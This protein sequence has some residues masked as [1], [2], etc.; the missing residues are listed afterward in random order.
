[1]YTNVLKAVY[2]YLLQLVNVVDKQ[3]VFFTLLL[4]AYCR[5]SQE[6]GPSSTS[7]QRE[8][9]QLENEV[10]AIPETSEVVFKV[11]EIGVTSLSDSKAVLVLTPP[12]LEIV[13]LICLMRELGALG[14][15]WI[16]NIQNML[17]LDPTMSGHPTSTLNSEQYHFN[18]AGVK[19][20]QATDG[21]GTPLTK[22]RQMGLPAWEFYYGVTNQLIRQNI[23][24]SI[25][26]AD[27]LYQ[28][29]LSFGAA[30]SNS[31]FVERYGSLTKVHLEPLVKKNVEDHG[32]DD[33]ENEVRLR[34]IHTVSS[35]S[36]FADGIVDAETLEKRTLDESNPN[37]IFRKVGYEDF[38]GKFGKN[39]TCLEHETKF[40]KNEVRCFFVHPTANGTLPPARRLVKRQFGAIAATLVAGI[41]GFVGGF[42][43]DKQYNRKQISL[44][45]QALDGQR[46]DLTAF[47]NLVKKEFVISSHNFLQVQETMGKI[48][49][50][51][52]TPRLKIRTNWQE[53]LGNS[54][55]IHMNQMSLHIRTAMSHLKQR[56]AAGLSGKFPIQ[57]VDEKETAHI[58][59]S[60]VDQAKQKGLEPF[61]TTSAALYGSACNLAA[62]RSLFNLICTVPLKSKI[63]LKVHYIPQQQILLGNQIVN[64]DL[65]EKYIFH[66][67]E[68]YSLMTESNLNKNC[69]TLATEKEDYISCDRQTQIVYT[70]EKAIESKSCAYRLSNSIFSD[71]A[72]YC[73]LTLT[74][75]QNELVQ[76]FNQ[77]FFKITPLK[78]KITATRFCSGNHA[79]TQTSSSEPIFMKLQPGCRIVTPSHTIADDDLISGILSEFTVSGGF[80]E[81]FNASLEVFQ[82]LGA[83]KDSDEFF[84]KIRESDILPK[85]N[86]SLPLK[87]LNMLKQH[88]TLKHKAETYAHLMLPSIGSGTAFFLFFSII[89]ATIILYRWCAKHR[90][91]VRERQTSL[92]LTPLATTEETANV[93]SLTELGD[94]EAGNKTGQPRRSPTQPGT[95]RPPAHHGARPRSIIN[96]RRAIKGPIPLNLA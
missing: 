13:N 32:D 70:R 92:E 6:S 33:F 51:I 17:K 58:I 26:D 39:N 81:L 44:L 3:K 94:N 4:L 82:L 18:L 38:V 84:S 71:L 31:H 30:F 29:I 35:M 75:G 61:E 34:Y 80:K 60:L 28:K 49:S 12:T 9:S 5:A 62:H 19:P 23:K 22:K 96:P 37:S 64:L 79:D 56:F 14:Q 48:F 55:V 45:T 52:V 63:M 91:D 53:T 86:T 47:E 8:V 20:K 85:L 95:A 54:F 88:S 89:T 59:A 10:P 77:T 72:H 7:V 27:Q 78:G 41:A 11:Q 57:L 21:Q 50:L 2:L 76:K 73:P 40:I 90:E 87:E 83:F 16:L 69:R 24:L 93:E 65:P 46:S 67:S 66:D 42:S 68:R 25:D 15:H 36:D 43:S 74:L 1:M